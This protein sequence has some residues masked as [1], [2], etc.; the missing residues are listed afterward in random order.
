MNV[1]VAKSTPISTENGIAAIGVLA[2]KSLIISI[3]VGALFIYAMLHIKQA[4]AADL[5]MVSVINEDVLRVGDIFEN[6]SGKADIVIGRA[7]LPGQDMTLNARTLMRI[8]KSLNIS[9]QPQSVL[10]QVVIRR[11]ATM[12]GFDTVN[13]SLKQALNDKAG[14]DNLELVVNENLSGMTLPKGEPATADVQDIRY[15]P[16]DSSFVATLLAPSAERPLKRFKVTGYAHKLIEVPTLASSVKRGDIIS[17]SDIEM[18]ELRENMLSRNVITN[19]AD[20]Q[21]MAAAKD[22]SSSE[23]IRTMDIAL[24]QLV[25]R[26]GQLTIIYKAGTMSLTAKGKA[27]QNGARGELIRIVNLASNK[28]LQGM[29]TGD[30]EVTIY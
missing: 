8:A 16:Q 2:F 17:A 19:L 4:T 3:I 20:L 12:I 6:A 14:L 7:P 26:G 22:I 5:K 10:D 30:H 23:P 15:N 1:Y 28:N 11:E 18:I 9:W 13:T 27:L 25:E 21:G 29:V 24:P